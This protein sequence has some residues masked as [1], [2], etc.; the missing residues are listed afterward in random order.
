MVKLNMSHLEKYFLVVCKAIIALTIYFVWTVP[1]L[2]FVMYFIASLS[3]VILLFVLWY[4]YVIL[5]V[6]PTLVRK[7]DIEF[8]RLIPERNVIDSPGSD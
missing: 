7:A 1:F 5:E 6:L 8:Q 2:G 3:L 4:T